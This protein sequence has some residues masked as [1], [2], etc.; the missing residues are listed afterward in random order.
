MASNGDDWAIEPV[1][2]KGNGKKE[3]EEPWAAKRVK[4]MK[5]CQSVAGAWLPFTLSQASWISL[6][7]NPQLREAFQTPCNMRSL[8]SIDDWTTRVQQ[9]LCYY[10]LLE[11][12]MK[13]DDRVFQFQAL[14][15]G[16]VFV[17]LESKALTKYTKMKVWFESS[18]RVLHDHE[19]DM[20][21]AELTGQTRDKYLWGYN[22]EAEIVFFIKGL[23]PARPLVCIQRL[24]PDYRDLDKWAI[25]PGAK[26]KCLDGK[27]P[28]DAEREKVVKAHK[29]RK[30]KSTKKRAKEREVKA[31]EK[32]VAERVA[33]ELVL[34]FDPAAAA[35]TA[36]G[37]KAAEEAAAAAAS[38]AA[39]GGG[40]AGAGAEADDDD[41]KPGSDDEDSDREDG[42]PLS[43]AR[44]RGGGGGAGGGGGGSAAAMPA[45]LIRSVT[46][47]Y[48]TGLLRKTR[49]DGTLVL[50]MLWDQPAVC[51]A[52]LSDPTLPAASHGGAGLASTIKAAGAHGQGG[53]S[54]G[55]GGG[56]GI[57]ILA[58][59][60]KAGAAVAAVAHPQRAQMFVPPPYNGVRGVETW[61]AHEALLR[62]KRR[63]KEEAEVDE[64]QDLF[65]QL[66]AEA[67]ADQG[68]DR[69]RGVKAGGGGGGFW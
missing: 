30:Q 6:T 45:H 1:A 32:A 19:M 31:E 28:S 10:V 63:E 8:D 56:T 13:E 53:S 39:G 65:Q 4:D 33:L 48:G 54:G 46:T 12:I 34:R 5:H 7:S 20:R 17:L 15:R 55:G 23:A 16:W 61:G 57:G 25:K 36:Q 3:K 66:L 18:D 43:P 52:E 22:P 58:L 37:L 9:A 21:A 68:R 11:M 29:R 35:Q 38:A 42:V 69:A 60:G 24:R 59:A 14:G 27:L 62:E 51:S 2:A 64:T 49:A 67:K 47:A 40:G 41:D 50:D 44:R 26:I